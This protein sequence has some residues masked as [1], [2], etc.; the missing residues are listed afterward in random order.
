MFAVN[1][2]WV[3]NN[4]PYGNSVWTS[5]YFNGVI[6]AGSGDGKI[7]RTE[8][9]GTTWDICFEN[10]ATWRIFY[11]LS[12]NSIIAGNANRELFVSSDNG[13]TWSPVNPG[14]PEG[15]DL[16]DMIEDSNHNLYAAT[17]TGIFKS[18]DNGANW[19]ATNYTN[20][21]FSVCVDN[22]NN[23]Y[24]ASYQGIFKSQDQGQ[25]WEMIS[26]NFNACLSVEYSNDTIY[27][28]TE[29]GLYKYNGTQ[30][31]GPFGSDYTMQ[32]LTY[33]SNT[34]Y[35]GTN[36]GIFYSL[37]NGET[38][39][40]TNMEFNVKGGFSVFENSI[41]AATLEGLYI[42]NAP[43]N[44]KK[45]GVPI[46]VA[47]VN[48]SNDKLFATLHNG[49]AFEVYMKQNH[50]DDWQMITSGSQCTIYNVE[51]RS[52][53][54]IYVGMSG[55]V[56]GT[57]WMHIYNPM[58]V[59]DWEYWYELGFPSEQYMVN[60]LYIREN[61]DVFA[62][63]DLGVFKVDFVPSD[64]APEMNITEFGLSD[65]TAYDFI[66]GLG[67]DFL[68]ATDNGIY[69]FTGNSQWTQYALVGDTVKTLLKY[70]GNFYA[71]TNNGIFHS[72]TT[73]QWNPVNTGLNIS[74]ITKLFI[75]DSG[76]LGVICNN[77]LYVSENNGQQWNLIDDTLNQW[78]LSDVC[79]FSNRLILATDR[80]IYTA[81]YNPSSQHNNTSIPSLNAKIYPNPFNPSTNISFELRKS[82]RVALDIYNIKGQL[83]K[84][85]ANHNFKA[86]INTLTWDGRDN[87]SKAQSSGVYFCKI[88][89]G[90]N[91]KTV[92]M[93]LV[94]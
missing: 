42:E 51:E 92:K 53:S 17:G 93:L 16:R 10:E 50:N 36:N 46:P 64:V 73:D 66:D 35:A 74:Q 33:K 7:Y 94:K 47:K 34:L 67:D 61:G 1:L 38:W 30:W 72:T 19:T 62:S 89:T 32:F 12:N 75:T 87:N 79:F 29:S 44:W 21:A 83:V 81:V 24:A 58:A 22:Q 27:A 6:L 20:Y 60:G 69:K 57:A 3:Q 86:G 56:M 28:G 59:N 88:K 11:K 45:I 40:T 84:K 76:V 52:D 41:V 70:N 82:E 39:N 18:T 15:F 2:D 54:T 49:N 4:G 85:L 23:I 78:T 26:V 9:N 77:N 91:T 37:D 5:N 71:L 13:I 90:S 65:R 48:V 31:S 43:E 63:G 68:S 14:L 25:N 80:G 8:N 55:G